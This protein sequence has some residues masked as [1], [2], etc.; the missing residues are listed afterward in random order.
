MIALVLM[1][2]TD[3]VKNMS[4][5]QGREGGTREDLRRFSLRWIFVGTYAVGTEIPLRKSRNTI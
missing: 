4:R 1:R 5:R 2:T 3:A